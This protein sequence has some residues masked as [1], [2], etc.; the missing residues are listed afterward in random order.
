MQPLVLQ[1]GRFGFLLLL[2]FFIWL[3]L[4]TL[5]NDTLAASFDLAT[6]ARKSKKRRNTRSR[7]HLSIPEKAGTQR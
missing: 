1:I 7:T 5:K 3:I 2:W 4:H 6:S